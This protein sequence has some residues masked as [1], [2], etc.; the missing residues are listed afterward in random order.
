MSND[1]HLLHNTTLIFYKIPISKLNLHEDD[2]YSNIMIK[3]TD[4]QII[5]ILSFVLSCSFFSDAG[6]WL[7]DLNAPI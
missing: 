1:I 6:F 4:R 7:F 2:I 3:Y 5:I